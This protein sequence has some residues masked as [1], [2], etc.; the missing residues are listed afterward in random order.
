[1]LLLHDKY[2]EVLDEAGAW[3]FNKF[4]FLKEDDSPEMTAHAASIADAVVTHVPI[5]KYIFTNLRHRSSLMLRRLPTWA[6]C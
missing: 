4:S 5:I 6:R 1:M 3:E 2:R